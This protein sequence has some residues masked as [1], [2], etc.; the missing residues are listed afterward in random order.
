MLLLYSFHTV[1][2]SIDWAILLLDWAILIFVFD[3]SLE[4]SPLFIS[5][6]NVTQHNIHNIGI[7]DEEDEGFAI[8]RVMTNPMY[9]DPASAMGGGSGNRS[10]SGT[11][12]PVHLRSK[13]PMAMMDNNN[14]DDNEDD[15][16]LFVITQ[17]DITQHNITYLPTASII[18][19]SLCA[20]VRG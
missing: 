1:P 17:V 12:T 10:R 9:Q 7:R 19:E 13:S 11:L 18:S 3:I 15:D 2:N 6:H 20:W 4:L 8:T 14:N 5:H 16:E